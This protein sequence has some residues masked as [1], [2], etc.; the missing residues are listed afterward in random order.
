MVAATLSLEGQI[1]I[2][3]GGSRGIG[4][5]ISL[6][7]ADHGATVVL[8]GRNQTA[9]DE[10]ATEL[11]KRGRRAL[12]VAADV[13]RT[14]DVERLVQTTLRT[15][16]RVD[17][18]VNSAGVLELVPI[19]D[20]TEA[21][22]ES[23]FDINL[24]GTFLCCQA[25][26]RVM[27]QQKWGSIINMSSNA[28][29][30]VFDACGAYCVAKAGLDQLTRALARQLGPYKVRVN[31]IA[32]GVVMTEMAR[33]YLADPERRKFAFSN[34]PLGFAAETDDITPLAVYL[35]SEA[36]RFMTGETIVIDGGTVA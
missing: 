36:S 33:E 8:C 20:T 35:A 11:E 2:V 30:R 6:A 13:S 32:P 29:V 16:G 19:L 26:G 17:T 9:A 24:K 7:F 10:V 25:V 23:T 34:I 22:W 4:K 18:L 31:G 15:F 27:M 14:E 5:A 1:A 21:Q 3:T 28:G 12:A